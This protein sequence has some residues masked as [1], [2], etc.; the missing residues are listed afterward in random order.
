MVGEFLSLVHDVAGY[1]YGAGL[2]NA[3]EA[4]N[5][6]RRV[7]YVVGHAIAF[8]DPEGDQGGGEPV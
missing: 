5:Q 1:R 8:C 7:L 4:G 3:E 6:F 2:E